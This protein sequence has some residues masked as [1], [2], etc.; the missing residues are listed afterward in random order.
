MS[1]PPDDEIRRILQETKTI[2]MVGASP[3]PDRPSYGVLGFL[4]AKGFRSWPVN[5]AAAGETIHGL[6]VLASLDEIG[7]PVDM[8]DV[9][10]RAPDV[11]PVA[12]AAIA[13]HAKTLWL[14]LG[15]INDE[16][17]AKARA[18]GL[19]VVQNAC[20]VIEWSR[21]GLR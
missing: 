9:F 4:L 14:Q 5:P 3:R 13:I 6:K 16:A 19:V 18:A 8:V 21:L 15:I 7:E 17:A 20:P 12:D 1:N 10:R 11:P 2:A